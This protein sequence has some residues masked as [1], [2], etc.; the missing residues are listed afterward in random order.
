MKAVKNA[1]EIACT[2]KAHL[3]DG[4]CMVQFFRWVKNAVKEMPVT[5]I[6]ASDYLD[7]QRFDTGGAMDLSFPTISGYGPHGAIIHYQ[8]T[9]ET[10][11][12]LRPEG[13][14]LVDSGGQ[15]HDGTTDITRTIALGPLSR[16]MKECYTYVLKSHIALATTVFVPGTTGR[17]LDRI[18]R[19]P[20]R[21]QGLDF[22]HGTGHGVGHML[23]V[24]EGPNMISPRG[25]NCVFVPGMITSNEPGVYLPGEFGIRLENEILCVERNGQYQFETIT[26]CPFERAAILPALLTGQE[27]AWVN[28][29]HKAVREHL[30]PRLDR[31][32][33]AWLN[34]ATAPLRR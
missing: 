32:A 4:E 16:K 20:L 17:E 9:G 22:R 13:F 31:N 28:H 24:H 11:A 12:E 30:M 15:Y 10:D 18:A 8:A 26:F 34:A 7:W 1:T 19:A 33:R 2:R 25:G 6:D 29:Y 5:E 27:L 21:E 23:S 3:R 14:L